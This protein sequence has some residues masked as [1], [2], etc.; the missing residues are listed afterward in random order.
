MTFYGDD[1]DPDDSLR[2][3]ESKDEEPEYCDVCGEIKQLYN[4]VP[5]CPNCSGAFE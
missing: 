1:Y 4:G 3:P 2:E 5:L